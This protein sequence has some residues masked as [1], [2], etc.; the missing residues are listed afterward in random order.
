MT[1]IAS[2]RNEQL[3]KQED[4]VIGYLLAGYPSQSQFMEL[5]HAV[6]KTALDALEIGYPSQNPYAD[7][8]IIKAAHLGVD[9]ARACDLDY[10]RQIRETVSKPIWLMAYRDDFIADGTYVEFAQEQIMD[11]I[12]IPDCTHEEHVRLG[13]ELLQHQVDVIRFIRP[14]MSQDEIKRIAAESALLYGQL[15]NGPTG[16]AAQ[17]QQS[18]QPMLETVLRH[19]SARIYAG[20][21]IDGR[22]KIQELLGQ[23]FHGTILGTALIKRLNQSPGELLSYLHHIK[24][25]ER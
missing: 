6:E 22:D 24:G 14:T 21:G 10:W 16:S 11:A 25:G 23:G 9:H 19:S 18:Y 8:E 1:I 20:F 5:L 2:K 15:Y 12:V 7:G 13:E 4:A 3:A 17:E